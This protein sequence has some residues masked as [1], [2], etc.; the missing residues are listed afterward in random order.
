MEPEMDDERALAEIE[1]CLARDDPE[2]ATRITALNEQFPR[3]AY[4][5]GHGGAGERPLP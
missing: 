5:L 3:H 1:R 4:T 2:L